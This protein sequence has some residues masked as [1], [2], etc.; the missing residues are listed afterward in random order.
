MDLKIA[1]IYIS[2]LGNKK[3]IDELL[4]AIKSKNKFIRYH[5]AMKIKLKYIPELHF[6]YD[7]TMK[8]AEK[9]DILINKIHHDD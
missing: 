8:H 7:D 6:Y 9:I 5:V 4:K 1:N 3:N 2:F